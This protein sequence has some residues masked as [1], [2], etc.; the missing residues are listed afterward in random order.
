MSSSTYITLTLTEQ[1]SP[2]ADAL[3]TRRAQRPNAEW[4]WRIGLVQTALAL[5][6]L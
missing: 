6:D 3:V 4:K 5:A 2:A 1:T